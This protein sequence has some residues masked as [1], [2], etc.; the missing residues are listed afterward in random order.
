MNSI[1][2]E[3]L[4]VWTAALEPMKDF[5]IRYFNARAG[6]KYANTVTGF[7][8]YFLSFSSGARLELMNA[9]GLAA[10][11][12]GGRRAGLAHFAVSLGGRDAVTVLT[13]SMRRAGVTVVS[14]PRLTGD[15]YFESVVLDPDGNRLELTE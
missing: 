7:S 1:K 14:K 3:H 5:Y 10:G 12:R 13:E 4:A 8:S 6:A 11:S 2:I 15:G 9:P